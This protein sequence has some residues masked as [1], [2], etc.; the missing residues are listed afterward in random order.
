MPV[1]ITFGTNDKPVASKALAKTFTIFPN[2][3]GRLFI[4]FPVIGTHEGPRRI[5]ALWASEKIGFVAFDLVEGSD[6]SGYRE[7]QNDFANAIESKLRSRSDLVKRINRR[8]DLLVSVHTVT[9]IPAAQLPSD[10]DSGFPIAN[11]ENLTAVLRDFRS[12]AAGGAREF[13]IA[14]SALES[15]STIR[16]T[17]RGRSSMR[18]D[19]R[20]AKL[21]RLEDSVAVLDTQQLKAMI[22]TTTGV[23]RIRGLAGSGKTIV[24]ALKAAYLHVQHPEW[25]IAVTFLTRALK[26]FFHRLINDSFVSQTNEAPDW[27]KLRI[28]H[29]WGASG[30]RGRDGIYHQFCKASGV[31]YLDYGAAR[32][33]Y[34]PMNPFG[35]ACDLAITEARSMQEPVQELYDVILIDEAQDLPPA[36][37]QLCYGFLKPSKRLVYAYD[38]LQNLGGDPLPSP[39]EIFGKDVRRPDDATTGDI[40]LEKCYRNSRPVL[41][42]AHALGFGIHRVDDSSAGTGIVQMFD[43]PEMWHDLGYRAVGGA[44]RDGEQVVLERPEDA[45]PKFLEDHSELDDL[46]QFLTFDTE[47]EQSEWVAQEIEEAVQS[48]DLKPEEIVVINPDPLKTPKAVGPTRALLVDKAIQNHLAGV[49]TE[50]DVFRQAGSVTFT[51]IYRAKGNEFG[52]VYIINAHECYRAKYNLARIRNRLFTAITRSKAWIRVCGVGEDMR[53]LANEHSKLKN[54]NYRMQFV[55][56]TEHQRRRMRIVQRDRADVERVEGH[57]SNLSRIIDDFKAGRIY[58]EDIAALQPKLRELVVGEGRSSRADA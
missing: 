26:D 11:A 47:D 44:I 30:D 51:G 32:R 25:N 6:Y 56:P 28:I 54:A 21:K 36:F 33:R 20:G 9:F 27:N 41:T 13:Q 45:S 17:M 14:L 48:H 1:D 29:A 38:E 58:R 55:Y 34:G 16:R 4:G 50:A 19:S 24:L 35:R 39:D 42:T 18:P 2:L 15:V 43:A 52:M 7:R 46:I 5:D 3:S 57:I 31:T 40:V 10:V 49:D 12:T 8:R 53:K 37:L 23:Q 22:E